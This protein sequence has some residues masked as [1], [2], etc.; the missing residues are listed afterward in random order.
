MQQRGDRAD[1]VTPAQ[2]VPRGRLQQVRDPGVGSG[3]GA[4]Q[5]PGVPLRLVDQEVRQ[6]QVCLGLAEAGRLTPLVDRREFP[7]DRLDEAHALVRD[8]ENRGKVV[9]TVGAGSTRDGSAP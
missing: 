9:V 5:G 2:R 3:R 1:G 8:G 4:G 7:L 6:V